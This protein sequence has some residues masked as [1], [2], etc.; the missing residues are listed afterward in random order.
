[1]KKNYSG[2]VARR[3]G[4]ATTLGFPTINIPLLGDASGIFAAVVTIDSTHY[5]AA[6]Y[7]DQKRKTLEAYLLDVAEALGEHRWAHQAWHAR[8]ACVAFDRHWRQCAGFGCLHPGLSLCDPVARHTPST[9]AT[10]PRGRTCRDLP[11]GSTYQ[12]LLALGSHC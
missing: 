5:P 12:A 6:V 2:V 10:V 3:S 7:A 1:M 11:S 9:A 4:F 8:M